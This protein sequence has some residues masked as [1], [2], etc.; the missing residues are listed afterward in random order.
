MGG[1]WEGFELV[2]FRG[3]AGLHSSVQAQRV[4]DLLRGTM[5]GMNQGET[6]IRYLHWDLWDSP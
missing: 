6:H 5:S 4:S 1:D 3:M 2:S